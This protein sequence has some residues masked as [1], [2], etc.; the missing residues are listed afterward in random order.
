MRGVSHA[1]HAAR[2]VFFSY[3]RAS[4]DTRRCDVFVVILS[5]GEGS[6]FKPPAHA[7]YTPHRDLI[8]LRRG[9]P[10]GRPLTTSLFVI[11]AGLKRESR[12]RGTAA[13][14]QPS[15]SRMIVEITSDLAQPFTSLA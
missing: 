5:D 7:D 10:L 6:L 8:T 3:S 2:V 11:P 4:R 9:D 1:C 14:F 15:S 13:P 12:M